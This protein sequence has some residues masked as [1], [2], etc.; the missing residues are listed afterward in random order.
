MDI[1]EVLQCLK[2]PSSV[3]EPETKQQ[4]NYQT[5]YQTNT[6]T[7]TQAETKQLTDNIVENSTQNNYQTEQQANTQA[8][9]QTEHQTNTLTEQQTNYQ[10]NNITEQI[11]SDVP[12]GCDF[13]QNDAYSLA[14]ID[15]TI[16]SSDFESFWLKLKDSWEQIRHYILTQQPNIIQNIMKNILSFLSENISEYIGLELTYNEVNGQQL[17][18]FKGY[19]ELYISP[20][21]KLDNISVMKALYAKRIELPNLLVSCYRP[22]HIKDPLIQDIEYSDFKASYDNF[23]YQGSLAQYR[24]ND[25]RLL[26]ILNVVIL[27]KAP[28][29]D[30]LLKKTTM[31]FENEKTREVYIPNEYDAIERFLINA[32]GEYN[33]L[34]HVGYIEFISENDEKY[35]PTGTFTELSDIRKD[36]TLIINHMRYKKCNYCDHNELQTKLYKCVRC[37][38]TLYCS[39]QCQ[40]A[41]WENHRRLCL[42]ITNSE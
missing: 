32:I 15:L 40:I 11:N 2:T 31:T 4:A 36:I 8:N 26:P 24:S 9:Y 18:S 1:K 19:I 20:A 35:V 7:N 30:K 41:N 16:D 22:F 39:K 25:G 3:I 6:L 33:I 21:H 12:C 34:H 5:N 29:C 28:V 37:Q 42:Y 23:G 13:T 27:V 14:E 38:T 10:T 17:E